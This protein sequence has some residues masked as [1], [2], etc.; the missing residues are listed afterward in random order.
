[1]S[2]AAFEPKNHGF[3]VILQQKHSRRRRR[4]QQTKTEHRLKHRTAVHWG[5]QKRLW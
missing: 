1:M 3:E 4:R 2:P 5:L